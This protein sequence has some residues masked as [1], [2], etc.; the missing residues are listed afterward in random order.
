M[1][2]RLVSAAASVAAI[3]VTA[4][5]LAPS[6]MA[7]PHGGVCQLSGTATFGTPLTVSS[8]PFT[9]TF[10]GTLSSCQSTGGPSGGNIFTPNSATGTGGC[11]SS[12]TNGIAVVQWSSGTTTVEQ[13]STTGAAA[14]VALQGKVIAST[15]GPGPNG[16]TITYTTN[17][18]STPVG[19][20]AGGL[21]TF[22]PSN[23]PTGCNSGV[24]SAAINGA[25]GTGGQ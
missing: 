9:Y 24:P 17:E 12:T 4:L 25:V 7:T 1:T 16:T 13:Y 22:N 23:G 11:V 6:A 21:V 3:G 14:A 5:A 19:D 18:P 2:K 15:T 10:S 20:S 8:Q